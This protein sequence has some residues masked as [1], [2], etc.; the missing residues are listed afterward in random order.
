MPPSPSRAAASEARKGDDRNALKKAAH[1]F[2]EQRGKVLRLLGQTAHLYGADFAILWVAPEGQAEV[3]ASE[4]LQGRF[5]TW[6]DDTV[7]RDAENCVRRSRED[8]DRKKREGLQVLK[9]DQVFGD[10]GQIFDPATGTS[11]M[12]CGDGDVGE[13]DDVAG[14]ATGN[15]DELLPRLALAGPGTIDDTLPTPTRVVGPSSSFQQDLS[16]PAQSRQPLGPPAARLSRSF[17][18]DNLSTSQYSP[19]LAASP[20]PSPLMPASSPYPP[21]APAPP[22]AT[23]KLV[24]RTF[25]PS[26]LEAW[27]RERISD[28]C[29]KVD[30]LVCK[31]WIKAVEPHKQTRYPYQKGDDHKPGWWPREIRHKEPDHLNKSER[32]A[33]LLHILRSGPVSVDE[34]ELATAAVSVH[35]STD[36]MAI[37]HEIYHVAREEKVLIDQSAGASL[38]MIFHLPSSPSVLAV[39]ADGTY[40]ELS[41]AL[42]VSS[43][44]AEEP[45]SPPGTAKQ[46]NTR[47]RARRSIGQP[48]DL[49]APQLSPAGAARVP[50]PLQQTPRAANRLQPYPLAR[51]HSHSEVPHAGA[52]AGTGSEAGPSRSPVPPSAGMSR[53]QSLAGPVTSAGRPRHV[54]GSRRDTRGALLDEADHRGA[55]ALDATPY[56]VGNAGPSQ[57]TPGRR[58]E[59]GS[60]LAPQAASMGRS[61]SASAAGGGSAGKKVARTIDDAVAS[62]AMLKSRSRLSQQH[63]DQMVLGA[64]SAEKQQRRTFAAQQQHFPVVY[65]QALHPHGMPPQ[66][67]LHQH[68]Q[69]QLAQMQAQQQLP[70]PPR[71]SLPPAPPGQILVYDPYPDAIS[72]ALPQP[73]PLAR[74]LSAQS[75]GGHTSMQH[76]HPPVPQHHQHHQPSPVPPQHAGF[77]ASPHLPQLPYAHAVSHAHAQMHLETQMRHHAVHHHAPAPAPAGGEFDAYAPG[78]AG[79]DAGVRTGTGAYPTPTTGTYASP[80]FAHA[81]SAGPGGGHGSAPAAVSAGTQDGFLVALPSGG[82]PG[83]GL[84]AYAGEYGGASEDWR[85]YATPP[86]GFGAEATMAFEP[87]YYGGEGEDEFGLLGSLGGDAEEQLRRDKDEARRR[88]EEHA[89]GQVVG[90]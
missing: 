72:S 68:H 26:E 63:F 13:G 76:G 8:K 71:Q 78:S 69:Q 40:A 66:F 86:V 59:Q 27:Y 43:S 11:A 37:L 24:R 6:L 18:T 31:R 30:K 23:A 46:H 20:L 60:P 22:P 5:R 34:L 49:A 61:F 80:H 84:D 77:S 3:Y 17:A 67:Q 82:P 64:S 29:Y 73:P 10:Q 4:A 16:S 52:G 33:L 81:A 15:A 50:S 32:V 39:A 19:N 58:G 54:S 36:K 65:E 1:R 51:S 87:G 75:A 44:A 21:T 9:G 14:H 25:T 88:Y 90:A 74:Q 79:A 2:R 57:V 83:G 55:E 85:V 62:P 12:V 45:V 28:L 38:H 70:P 48:N 47:H 53:S 56:D 41:V 89:F 42:E 35:I 7:Q